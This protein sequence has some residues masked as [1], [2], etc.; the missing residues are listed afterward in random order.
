MFET[1]SITTR[2]KLR[3]N[4]IYT[5]RNGLQQSNL[6]PLYNALIH[7]ILQLECQKRNLERK[8]IYNQQE[9]WMGKVMPTE[10]MLP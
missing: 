1:H 3:G 10:Q 4:R 7:K 8:L 2:I 5:K 6:I 9:S